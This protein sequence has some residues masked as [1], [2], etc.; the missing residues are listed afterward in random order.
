MSAKQPSVF[1]AALLGTVLWLLAFP[2]LG[3]APLGWLAAVPW[4]WL[5]RLPSLPGRRPYLWI[6]LAGSLG[7][8]VL[9]EGVRRPH[10]ILYVGWFAL[11][12]YLGAYLPVFIA[13]VRSGGAGRSWWWRAPAAWAGLEWVRSWFIGCSFGQLAHTQV[14][15]PIWLQAADLCGGYGL[16]FAMILTSACLLAAWQAPD[17]R[18]RSIALSAAAAVLLVVAGYG[19]WSLQRWRQVEQ[20]A[21]VLRCI[22]VQGSKDVFYESDAKKL[23]EILLELRDVTLAAVAANPEVD[24]VVWPEA[25]TAALG[26]EIVVRD[27]DRV[28]RAPDWSAAEQQEYIGRLQQALRDDL[29]LLVDQVNQA[30]GGKQRIM[31]LVGG[32]IVEL[33]VAGEPGG[34]RRFNSAWM[35]SSDGAIASRYSKVHRVMFGEFIPVVDWFPALYQWTPMP[36]GLTSGDGPVAMRVG[37]HVI[38]PSICFESTVPQLIRGQLAALRRRGEPAGALVNITNDGWFGGTT[39]LDLHFACAVFRAVEN[40]RPMAISANNGITAAITGSGVIAHRLP[41]REPNFLVAEIRPL[42]S[43]SVYAWW[44]D[45]PAALALLGRLADGMAKKTSDFSGRKSGGTR[46]N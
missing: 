19:G 29:R 12:A 31:M 15:W 43:D 10:P 24:L 35:L 17:V 40:R 13:I 28:Q 38:S 11:S 3:W 39:V 25:A 45:W 9:L 27:W 32:D 16:S 30:A 4:L 22:L 6:W 44:G 20:E 7:W 26:G 18:R 21:P 36:L 8:L 42:S 37:S 33:G 14:E 5:T 23:G 2:P 34:Q 41:R 46:L 1:G